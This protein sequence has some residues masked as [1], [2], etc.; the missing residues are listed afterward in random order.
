MRATLCRWEVSVAEKEL[1]LHEAAD[2]LGV[3]YMT[4]YRYV[5]LG[6]LDAAKIGGT[7]RV[8][9]D[10][11]EAFRAEAHA[12]T[13]PS[14]A[15]TAPT[16]TMRG[17]RRAPWSDRLE[18]R[19]TAGDAAGAWGVIEAALT[20]G[21]NLEEIYLDVL[22]PAMASIGERWASGELD[23]SVEH[24]A[25]GIAMR[26]I[27]RLGPRFARRGRTRGAVVVGAPAGERHSLPIAILA[28][29]VRHAGW[30]VSDLGADVPASSWAH[31]V[32][33]SPD[34][35]A[36][37]LSVS[38]EQHLPAAR[39]AV[40]AVRE[41]APHVRVVLGGLAVVDRDHAVAL[42]AHDV[43]CDGLSFVAILDSLGGSDSH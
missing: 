21:A 2:D 5:R 3:H 30:E 31:A 12:R 8:G 16:T 42:G 14:A 37:G 41:A 43:A 40:A 6:L 24:R 10:A 22:S 28:D 39:E 33:T 36:V 20:A 13:V 29:L 7:W 1:T 26:L 15:T 38:G 9:R 17:R 32:L 19:L 34:V 25:S 27:G 11:I 35:V 23:V 4:A 18:Q